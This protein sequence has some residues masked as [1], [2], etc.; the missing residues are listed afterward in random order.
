VN[1]SWR[2]LTAK[3]DAIDWLRATAA[4]SPHLVEILPC[5]AEAGRRT[6][7]WLQVTT[8]SPLG[9]VALHTGGLLVDE[10]WLRILGAGG[11]RLPRTLESWN[12][13][14]P[15][16]TLGRLVADDALGG[17][18]AWFDEARTVHYLAP[19]TLRWEDLGLGYTD[20]LAAMLG[21]GLEV[22]YA[23]LRWE[24]WREEVRALAGDRAL[25]VWPPLV[26]AGPPLAERSRRPVPMD[27]AWGLNQQLAAKLAD[28]PDGAPFEVR[29]TGG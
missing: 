19:D 20:W 12:G 9:A 25:L 4:S 28:M 18:F 7:E 3:D 6:L 29:A 26:A 22:F 1:R 13:A 23:S 16:L 8:R 21:D 10:G 15:R 11:D 2:D 14:P 24:G 17:C 27:E 5:T